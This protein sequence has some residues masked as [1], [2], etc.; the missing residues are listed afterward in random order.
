MRENSKYISD[1][2]VAGYCMNIMPEIVLN[3]HQNIV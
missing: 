2:Y 1:K 3:D